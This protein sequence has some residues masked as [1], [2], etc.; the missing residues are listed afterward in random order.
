[1]GDHK[2]S[3]LEVS[4]HYNAEY[5]AWQKDIGQFGSWAKLE[6]YRALVR[7]SDRVLDFGC[8]GAFLLAKLPCL[9]RFGIEPNPEAR[10]AAKEN[11]VMVF[12]NATEA[13]AEL[14]PGTVDVIISDNALEHTLEP[15]RELLA[16]KPLLVAGG[17]L[18]ITIPCETIYW[19]Y[20]D[21]DINQHIYSWGPQSLGNL[22]NAA[23]FQ[24]V[25]SRPY[26]NKWPPRVTQKLA[27]LGRPIF[28]LA[29]RV[30]G[31]IDRRWFQVEALA[32]K[33]ES[34]G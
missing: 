14:G 9:D 15:Y 19:K 28:N 21:D 20:R 23:G 24:V 31:H 34:N 12:A 6:R 2:R 29:S 27:V 13:L 8:G 22:L 11:G 17:V 3:P 16:L 26:I 10:K 30:W 32:R 25:Y 18:H 4:A 33:P 1:M 7:S 5:F